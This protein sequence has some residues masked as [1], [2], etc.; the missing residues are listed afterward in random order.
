M[1][2][3]YYLLWNMCP[4]VQGASNLPWLEFQ[5][6]EEAMARASD[7]YVLIRINKEFKQE[8]VRAEGLTKY[9]DEFIGRAKAGVLY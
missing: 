6:E 7:Y 5:T 9:H 8:F 3:P 1:K 2:R 4:V